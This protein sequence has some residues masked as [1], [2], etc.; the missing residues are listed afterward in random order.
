M[1]SYRATAF[2]SWG[3]DL[4]EKRRILSLLVRLSLRVP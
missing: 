3:F 2:Q 1:G 4:V